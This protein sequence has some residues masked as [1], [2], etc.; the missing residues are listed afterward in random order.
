MGISTLYFYV[1]TIILIIFDTKPFPLP[2]EWFYR[3]Q[4]LKSSF[5][6]LSCLDKILMGLVSY[7]HKPAKGDEGETYRF[8]WQ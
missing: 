2:E 6:L 4:W 1:K 5:G 8:K 7:V 3:I